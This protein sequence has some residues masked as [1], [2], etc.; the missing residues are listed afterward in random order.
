MFRHY[1]MIAYLIIDIKVWFM[2][3]DN[4]NEPFVLLKRWLSKTFQILPE[5]SLIRL[6]R[7]FIKAAVKKP[8]VLSWVSFGLHQFG[9]DDSLKIKGL[10]VKE[11]Q[12][13]FVAPG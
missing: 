12:L 6:S 4:D 11:A 13:T 5:N 7:H 9:L 2:L 8:K 3:L 1:I 10:K